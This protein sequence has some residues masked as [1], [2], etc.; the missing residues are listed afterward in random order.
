MPRAL[1]CSSGRGIAICARS[2]SRSR[3]APRSF[4]CRPGKRNGPYPVAVWR[5]GSTRIEEALRHH[6][7][8][9]AVHRDVAE[10]VYL[11]DELAAAQ[12]RKAIAD[13]HRT[14]NVL[15]VDRHPLALQHE[16]P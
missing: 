2:S 1:P 11:L 5:Y 10:L 6:H 3:L 13:Q 4:P 12:H 16:S 15:D 8:I 14:R 7:L 9:L